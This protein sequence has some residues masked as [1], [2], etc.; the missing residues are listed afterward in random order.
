[1]TSHIQTNGIS[2]KKILTEIPANQLLKDEKMLPDGMIPEKYNLTFG[3]VSDSWHGGLYSGNGTI[4]VMVYADYERELLRL[5]L[6]NIRYIDKRPEEMRT[7]RVSCDSP[8]LEI[9]SLYLKAPGIRKNSRLTLDLMRGEI[10]GE[11]SG[12]AFRLFTAREP[13]VIVVETTL[14]MAFF[15]PAEARSLRHFVCADLPDSLP[16]NPRPICGEN[17]CRQPLLKGK[18]FSTVWKKEKDTF[19]IACAWGSEAEKII[20]GCSYTQAAQWREQTLLSYKEFYEKSFLSVPDP[21]LERFYCINLYK[22]HSAAGKENDIALDLLGPWPRETA[23]C[24]IWWNLNIQLTYQW[25][26][27]AN[28][29]EQMEPLV[30]MLAD[31]LPQLRKNSGVEGG[32]GIGRASSY[33][34][35]SPLK[36]EKGNLPWVCHIL[37]ETFFHTGKA[38]VLSLLKELLPGVLKVYESLLYTTEDGVI[39]I[40]KTLPP[41]YGE[42]EDA[43][44]DLALLRKSAEYFLEFFR[45]DP[46]QEANRAKY[47][48]LLQHLTD[49]ASDRQ[50]GY[51]MGKDLAFDHSHPHTSHLFMVY[52]LE[53][54]HDRK[55]ALKSIERFLS[56]KE[57]HHGYSYTNTAAMFVRYGNGNRAKQL[58]H[59]LLDWMKEHHTENFL[60]HENGSPVIETPFAFNSVLQDM[61]LLSSKELIRLFPA[62]PDEWNEASFRNFHCFGNITIDA[63]FHRK[64]HS[65]R[66]RLLSPEAQK[67]KLELPDRTLLELSL[68][69]DCETVLDLTLQ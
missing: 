7:G 22:W 41:E 52:P 21:E 15:E 60:Y 10:R 18:Y 9:G 11:I 61:L 28:R 64:E 8:R 55:T 5:R 51:R 56:M 34:C 35:I 25:L 65:I 53:L 43:N 6:G 27:T 47:T 17:F 40:K 32:M 49:Y 30:K 26:Q 46:L 58:L 38:E 4:G 29:S 3:P 42:T 2:V 33:D 63:S 12:N 19:F 48:F 14:Q 16:E 44:F 45:D 66:C 24:A 54:P 62:V 31:H 59:T 57:E 36:Q 23:W 13:S 69:K 37:A 39:H 50:T 67:I 20:E 68:E 1:M